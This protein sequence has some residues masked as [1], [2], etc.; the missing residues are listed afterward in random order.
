M[1]I[2]TCI[3]ILCTFNFFTKVSTYSMGEVIPFNENQ[4]KDMKYCLDSVFEMYDFG[5]VCEDA[6]EDVS[7][8]F[9]KVCS[10]RYSNIWFA[11]GEHIDTFK[12][13]YKDNSYMHMN[14]DTCINY[15][16]YD[17]DNCD[18]NRN[19]DINSQQILN[20]I[21]LEMNETLNLDYGS[22]SPFGIIPFDENQYK[23]MKYCFNFVFKEHELEMKRICE[24]IIEDISQEFGAEC[25]DHAVYIVYNKSRDAF[26]NM[27]K[28]YYEINS[29]YNGCMLGNYYSAPQ[30]NLR[31]LQVVQRNGGNEPNTSTRNATSPIPK[32]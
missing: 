5:K 13:R 2:I 24:S 29:Y 14:Y 11:A 25:F 12:N 17:V 23:T 9:Q 4:Y 32:Q 7:F 8:D 1:K 22:N 18:I 26:K 27:P 10:D 19:A 28:N 31:F 16:L 3:M 30:E 6:L 21:K 15:C 20:E